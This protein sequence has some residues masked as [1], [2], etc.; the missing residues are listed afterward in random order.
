[1]RT[2]VTLEPD[3]AALVEAAMR[4]RSQPFKQVVNE[5]IRQAL[6]TSPKRK[7]FVQRTFSMGI[8]LRALT[9]AHH[10]AA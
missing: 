4:E 1:M 9:K 8:P 5:A 10:I 6:S 7:P 2:T 3:T